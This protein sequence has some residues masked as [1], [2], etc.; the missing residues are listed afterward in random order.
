MTGGAVRTAC[1]YCGVGCGVAG[2]PEGRALEVAGDP[3]HPSNFGRLCSKG[4]AL[5]ATV[6]LEGRLLTPMIGRRAASWSE[7]TALVAR[8]FRETI[9]RHG[10]DSVAFY[11]SGQLLTED[12]YVANKLMKGFIGSG[13]IDTNSRLCMAS[14]VVA[15]KQAF[16]A[17]LVPGCYEDLDLADL[18]V[19]S[20]HNAAWTHP[21]LFRRME[22]ARARGQRHVVIDPRRTDTAEVADL[23][24]ALAPQTDVR[25]W[26]GLLADLDRRGAL[27]ADYVAA[28]VSGFAE[29]KAALA[30]HD[31]SPAAV[32]ADCGL[33]VADLERFF[34]WFA[35]TARTVSLFSM[36]ANQSVQG[37]AKGLSIINAHLATGRIGKPGACPFSITGQPNAMGGRET[38]GMATTLAGH[39]DFDDV[40]RARVARF[41]GAQDVAPRPGLKAIEMFDAV[42][43][44]RIK[45]LW[46]MATNPAVSL[47][48]ADKV[49]AALA[50]CPFVVVSDCMAQTDTAAF[51]HVKLPALAW[52]EKDGTVTNSE[53]RISRQRRL[54]D[55]PGEA[56]ADW[57][58][59]ADVAGAMGWREAFDWRAPAQVFR[60]WARLTNYENQ[61]RM[62]SL[63]PLAGL[64]PE[65][66]EALEPVQWP[67]TAAGGTARLFEDGVFQTPDGRARMVVA[68]AK[69]P[70][71]AADPSFPL[72]LNTGRVRD[73]WHTLTRTGLAPDLC[74]HAPEPY[75]EVHPAD[76]EHLGVVDGAL[77]RVR[78]AQGEAVALAKVT[79]RQRPG[80]IF[81]PMHWT[82]AFAP[83]GRAN[84]LVAARVDPQSGQPEFKHTPARLRP[85]R[86]TWRGFFI[87]REAWSAPSGL[88]LVWRRIPQ[89]GCHLHEFAGRG[90]EAERE[91]LRRALCKG[92]AGEPL[93]F[94]D[95]AAGSLR[96]AY[97]A[98]E[99]LDRVLF[100][101]TR[102]AL[103]PR[104]WLAELFARDALGALD[105]AALLIGRAPGRVVESAPLVCACRGVRADRIGAAIAAGAATVDA[106]S[107]ATGAGSSCGSCRPEIARIIAQTKEVRHAA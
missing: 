70:A 63:G 92:A 35:Q 87:A 91:A 103:P 82:Q 15:H 11:V 58:I 104:D 73:H 98:G 50:A 78:T 96:E 89:H 94:E 10:P 17:D 54:F 62:L 85:Y 25:L 95:A 79:D 75:V 72:A 59:I 61:D 97:L 77:A 39:M 83:S 27:D 44:G 13:N 26:N 34:D 18:V 14:A 32:A 106:V 74:R 7:A 12:Y 99:A 46:V 76:A 68:E 60:E 101:A 52:G 81:M 69:G 38:G 42:A 24:L 47:P 20:G 23:H 9:A 51:A 107:D 19:F 53:R 41:W 40:S 65:A 6:G 88:D 31:Q 36:G 2:R 84:R 57:R 49:R 33:A 5:G 64:T 22:Q 55:P 56:R 8:R 105:R 16:G 4:S 102:G 90:D 100:T 48:D 21:V 80:A 45:A 43:E 71:Q 28:H 67:V 30:R 93:R 3:A 37:V 86:E 1:P 66:Y 29:V